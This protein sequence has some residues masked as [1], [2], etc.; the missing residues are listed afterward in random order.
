[1][2]LAQMGRL[3]VDL[4][5]IGM[6]RIELAPGKVGAEK[7]ERVAA[8]NRMV[9]GFVPEQAG[10]ADPMRIIGL[11]EVL[12]TGGVGDRG[13]KSLGNGHNLGMRSLASCTTI[14]DKSIARVQQ[15]RHPFEF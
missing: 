10:Q 6:I 13:P 7:K 2:A 3:D 11:K 4:N 9:G 12:A 15:F 14:N 1:M 8:Q 5:D